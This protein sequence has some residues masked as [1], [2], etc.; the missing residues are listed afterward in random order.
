MHE[1]ERRE[2]TNTCTHEGLCIEDR[3]KMGRMKWEDEVE[4]EDGE[5]GENGV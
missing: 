3:R 4:D 2:M 1:R 5:D